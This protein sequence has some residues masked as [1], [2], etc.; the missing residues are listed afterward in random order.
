M[1]VGEPERKR[2]RE[3]E[4]EKGGSDREVGKEAGKQEGN[5]SLGTVERADK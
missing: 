4:K 2:E 5:P 1:R 3:R